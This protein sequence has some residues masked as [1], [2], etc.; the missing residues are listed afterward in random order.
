MNIKAWIHASRL[1]TLPLA[2]SGMLLGSFIAYSEGLFRLE[3]FCLAFL[4]ILFLQI[5]SNWANDYGDFKHGTDNEN[6]VGPER[7]LQ[8]GAINSKT[9]KMAMIGLGFITFLTGIALLYISLGQLLNIMFLVYLIIGIFA[10]IAAIKYTVGKSNYGYKGF[11]DIMVFV[12]FGM[13]AVLGTY[14]LYSHQLNWFVILPSIS[15]GLLSTGVLNVNNMRDVENDKQQG[16]NTLAVKL[17]S[18]YSKIYHICLV[19]TALLLLNL[20]LCCQNKK[21]EAL[22]LLLPALLLIKHLIK[23]WLNDNPAKLDP[24]LKRLSFSTLLISL[25]TGIA[26]L[27]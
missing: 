12:F 19:L 2:A 23:V 26:L 20:F 21:W 4:T 27:L 22:S 18:K 7:T 8:S 15:I 6:R 16:K 24:E 14:F 25:W 17:G 9:M 1:R 5:L 13:A 3:V 11:G 10:I